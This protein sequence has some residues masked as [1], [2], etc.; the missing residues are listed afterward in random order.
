M[1]RR[2]QEIFSRLSWAQRFLLA[3]LLI[4][5][6]GMIGIGWWVGQQIESGVVHQTA[7]N[8]ALYVSSVVEPNLQQLT[9]GGPTAPASAAIIQQLLQDNSLGQH[10]TAM[11]V[12]DTSGKIV[13]AT[14]P[15][16][17]GLAF[18]IDTDLMHALHGWVASDIRLLDKPENI[19]DK[20]RGKRRLVTYTPV[21][22][23]GTNE[24]I[25]AVEFCQ[26]V[27]SLDQDIAVAKRN[28]WLVVGAATALMY[29]LLAGFVRFAS[30][31]IRR[32]QNELASQMG[33][34]RSLHE[35]VRGAAQRTTAVNE[36]SLRRISAELHDGPAQDLG[37]ALLRLE[38]L[39]PKVEHAA[40]VRLNAPLRPQELPGQ[41]DFSLVQTSLRHAM[42]E[43][44]AISA[45]MGLPE[46]ENLT[47]AET[48]ARAVETHEHRTGSA[49]QLHIGLM[50]AHAPLPVKIAVY[51][52]IQ[53]ALN[54][55]YCH[56][57]GRDQQVQLTQGGGCLYL[58]VADGGPG[59]DETRAAAWDEHLGLVG[60]RERA[61][62][63]GG[64]FS[65]SS[66]L[67]HGTRIR[68]Q[69]PLDGTDV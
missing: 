34:L 3:G 12:W 13:Y 17:I 4:L 52:I 45:G 28:S 11:K 23:T 42:K 57:D 51:R 66:E 9:A 32:Q 63:L 18:P 46:L 27:D 54:N 56:A 41:T 48:A 37:F 31:T 36:R 19:Y 22:R 38:H 60:M 69:L 10:I 44:R 65:I 2:M 6:S 43:I 53:E 21:R 64:S 61:E 35:R 33:Q 67:G 58:E 25:A 40:P 14:E 5:S 55:A 30:D 20:D 39:I 7:A 16:D 29:L 49:V 24:V 62:S 26:T 8:T 68:V 47:L 15:R 1:T 50:P 59:F